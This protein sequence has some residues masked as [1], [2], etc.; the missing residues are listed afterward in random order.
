MS[1]KQPPFQKG[2]YK[3]H[4]WQQML[5]LGLTALHSSVVN[6]T[7]QPQI[8][9]QAVSPNRTSRLDSLLNKPVQ[10]HSGRIRNAA[11]TDTP[12]AFTALFC[13][14]DNHVLLFCQATNYTFFIAT[15]VCF[16]YLNR[17]LQSITTGS[18]HSPSQFVQ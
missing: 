9:V 15:P 18:N 11:K 1:S 6:V 10:T 3:V 4:Q 7:F 2:D 12:N 14:N 13:R 16:I 5:A 17:S 8:G